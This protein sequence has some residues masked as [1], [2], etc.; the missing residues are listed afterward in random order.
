VMPGAVLGSECTISKGVFI[1]SRSHLGSQVKVGNHASLFGAR[2]EDEAFIGPGAMLLEDPAPRSTTPDGRRRG[3]SDFESHPT[4]VRRGATVGAGAILLPGVTVGQWA[5]VG[6]GAVVN[7]D[8]GAHGLATGNPAR[9]VGFV[10]TCG[11]R[12]DEQLVCACGRAFEQASDE[13]R[14]KGAQAVG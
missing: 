6:A 1:G 12:L 10:C 7:R 2:V 8:I 11:R 4:T 13:V 9:M 14:P 5:L 3:P